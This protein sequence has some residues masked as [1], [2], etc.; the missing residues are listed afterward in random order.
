[1][2][3]RRVGDLVPAGALDGTLERAALVDEPNGESGL[4]A[5][6]RSSEQYRHDDRQSW[7]DGSGGERD[8][9]VLADTDGRFHHT[10][11]Q[12]RHLYGR[13]Q[14][15]WLGIDPRQRAPHTDTGPASTLRFGDLRCRTAAVTE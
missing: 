13:V 10:L 15:G 7:F 4:L 8:C 3:V 5:D 6:A 2:P 9:G 11:S 1:M 12:Q 14:N